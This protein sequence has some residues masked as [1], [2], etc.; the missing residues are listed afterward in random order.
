[1]QINLS[2]ALSAVMASGRRI[3]P[4]DLRKRLK[5]AMGTEGAISV[6]R[7]LAADL[8]L[9]MSTEA[10]MTGVGDLAGS[11]SLALTTSGAVST[12]WTPAD[13]STAA[14]YDASDSDTITEAGGSVSQWDDKSGNGLDLTQ[15]TGSDQPDRITDGIHF[16]G[17][18]H[19]LDASG[20]P[21][22]YYAYIVGSPNAN[23]AYRNWL[24]TAT[25]GRHVLIQPSSADTVGSWDGNFDAA[26][27][28]TW[29][30]DELAIIRVNAQSST[31]AIAKNGNT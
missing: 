24:S 23:T 7:L 14:W 1:M 11:S 28:V 16:S 13:I 5:I 9:G 18:T 10:L 6:D 26:S 8:S 31:T 21:A 20:M 15:G 19:Q 27:G 3:R 4:G 22:T 17:S 12:A 29:A 2:V 25:A 30:Q